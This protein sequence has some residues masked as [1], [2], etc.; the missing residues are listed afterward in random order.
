MSRKIR[1]I[2]ADPLFSPDLNIITD[3][4]GSPPGTALSMLLADGSFSLASRVF[5]LEA[6]SVDAVFTSSTL[7][8]TTP[9]SD[10]SKSGKKEGSSGLHCLTYSSTAV[11]SLANF[12]YL[13]RRRGEGGVGRKKAAEGEGG[14]E[15]GGGWQRCGN[16]RRE[17]G[18]EATKCY[19]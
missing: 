17:L 14:G 18:F 9:K 19:V 11:Y 3:S 12:S 15:A 10:M 13:G 6:D 2:K 16:G 5:V 4:G 7:F 1:A 8:T